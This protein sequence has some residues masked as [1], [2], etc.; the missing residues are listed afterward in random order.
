MRVFDDCIDRLLEF[1]WTDCRRLHSLRLSIIQ[2]STLRRAFSMWRE[3]FTSGSQF[4]IIQILL[5]VVLF[6]STWKFTLVLTKLTYWN[7]FSSLTARLAL[8]L[9][10]ECINCISDVTIII[11]GRCLCTHVVSSWKSKQKGLWILRLLFCELLYQSIFYGA[12]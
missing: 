7:Y 5:V 6:V 8:W 10:L 2:W 1:I 4:V 9:H 3:P 12:A 11:S